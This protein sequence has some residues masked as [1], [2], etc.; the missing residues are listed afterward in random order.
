MQLQEMISQVLFGFN[1]TGD[2][3]EIP[4]KNSWRSIRIKFIFT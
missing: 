2:N 1:G 3:V 4:P